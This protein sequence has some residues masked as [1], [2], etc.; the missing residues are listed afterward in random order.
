MQVHSLLRI[1]AGSNQAYAPLCRQQ[2][3]R[4]NRKPFLNNKT[5]SRSNL[6]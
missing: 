4:N 1:S 6:P 2:F 5:L 3:C